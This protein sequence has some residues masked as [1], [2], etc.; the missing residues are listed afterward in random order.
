ML[1]FLAEHFEKFAFLKSIYLRAFISF[2]F[3]FSAVLIA[4]KPFIK[5]LKIKKLLSLLI[6]EPLCEPP[7]LILALPLLLENLIPQVLLSA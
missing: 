7:L 1:Y 2:V 3:A 4:G 5:Y 6:S